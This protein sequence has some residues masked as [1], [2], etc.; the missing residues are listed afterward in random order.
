MGGDMGMKDAI[1]SDRAKPKAP[2]KAKAY[3][4]RGSDVFIDYELSVAER[5]VLRER[6]VDL[7]DL[8]AYLDACLGD[9]YRV[10]TKWEDRNACYAVFMSCVEGDHRNSGFV[11][12][13]RGS[14]FGKALRQLAFKDREIM[15]GDWA[16]WA[17]N[18]SEYTLD[19]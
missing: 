15:E 5:E 11:L 12:S 16:H 6:G 9:G 1:V 19:D 4:P 3:A 17:K 18:S 8:F 7:V 13:G 2:R 14:T 10:T